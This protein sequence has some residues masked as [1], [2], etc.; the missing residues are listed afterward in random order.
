MLDPAWPFL[1]HWEPGKLD[2]VSF[3][4]QVNRNKLTIPQDRKGSSSH[5]YPGCPRAILP[6]APEMHAETPWWNLDPRSTDVW[7]PPSLVPI[8]HP[9]VGAH[10]LSTEE[11]F[12]L[13]V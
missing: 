9:H 11:V 7:G 12:P 8:P 5:R 3:P 6:L 10:L 4:F 13:L 2:C 1:P